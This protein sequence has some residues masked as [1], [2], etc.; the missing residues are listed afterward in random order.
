[1]LH[2]LKDVLNPGIFL[3]Q[4]NTTSTIGWKGGFAF[5]YWNLLALLPW[6][7]EILMINYYYDQRDRLEGRNCYL[8]TDLFWFVSALFVD[9]LVANLFGNIL[10]LHVRPHGALLQLDALALL[11]GRTPENISDH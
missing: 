7:L 3:Q 6:N 2:A 5:L 9:D 1:M 11:P 4:T 8:T 10:A